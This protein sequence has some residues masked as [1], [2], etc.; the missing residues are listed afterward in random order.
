ME[1]ECGETRLG[2]YALCVRRDGAVLLVRMAP[3]SPDA[4]SWTL[5]G[6]GVKFGEH[7]DDAV[8]RELRE[9]TGL[10]GERGRVV[11]VYSH[12]YERSPTRPQPP[13]QHLGLI[14]EVRAEEGELVNEVGGSTDRCRWVPQAE[15]PAQP[16]VE[17][18]AFAVAELVRAET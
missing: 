10:I 2:A 14:Y 18:A 5:P 8:L 15:L 16:L 3:D 9:E 17:L 7:P 1:G 6:G 4:G 13:F 12:T 11:A